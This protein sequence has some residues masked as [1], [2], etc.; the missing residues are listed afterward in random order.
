MDPVSHAVL[1]RIVTTA[2]SRERTQPRGTAAA[3]VL[4]GLSPDVDFV[5]MPFGWDIYLRAHEIGSHSLLGAVLTGLGSAC[6]VRLARTGSRFSVLART[7]IVAAL[8]HVLADIASGARLQPGWPFAGHVT[9]V[10]L[11]AMAD[12][13]PIVILLAGAA[14][15]AFGRSGRTTFAR[16]TFAALLVFLACKGALFALAFERAQ[17]DERFARGRDRVV[18]ARWA[19]LTEWSAFD[20]GDAALRQWRVTLEGAEL[21]FSIPAGP[22]GALARASRE[23]DTVRNFDAVHRLGFAVERDEG[24]GRRGVFWSDPRFCAR[25]ADD[26]E[27]SCAL[28]FGGIYDAEGRVVTQQVRVG[29]WIQNRPPPGAAPSP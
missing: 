5:L 19:S 22:G 12:P 7:A 4:G 3:A 13:G 18:E 2:L 1:G 24:T 28:W 25:P 23:L 29:S 14:L 16:A 20:R 6:L 8:S 21:G 9:S 10:P 15:M 27:V 11:V 17:A 26:R